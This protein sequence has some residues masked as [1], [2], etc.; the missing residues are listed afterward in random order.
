MN[1][2][3]LIGNGF[4]LAHGLRTS[5][6]DFIFW[7]WEKVVYK[8]RGCYC[9][10]WEDKL[11]TFVL[12]DTQATWNGFMFN[13]GATFNFHKG[14]EIIDMISSD[15]DNFNVKYSML[16]G[17]IIDSLETKGWV[18]IENDYYSLLYTPLQLHEQTPPK[19][20][21]DQLDY[22]KKQLADYLSE[23]QK[24]ALDKSIVNKELNKS[25]FAPIKSCEIAI[26]SKNSLSVFVTNRLND[27]FFRLKDLS[28]RWGKNWD[29][30]TISIISKQIKE[31]KESLLYQN[32]ED[33]IENEIPE[34]FL[35]PD[36]MMFLN[37]NYTEIADQYLIDS[38]FVVN[39]IHG[40]SNNVEGMIFGYG[41][42]LDENYK[43]IQNLNNNEYLKNSKSVR[44]LESDN[45]RK[46][47]SYI[48]SGPYQIYIMGHSCG[49]SDR[50]LLNTLFEHKNCVSIKPFYYEKDN[51]DDTYLEMVQNISRNFTDMKL[52]RDRVVNK[53]F[54]E[55]MPQVKN[56]DF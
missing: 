56:L 31:L 48:E 55:P 10:K 20:L 38:K 24:C 16:F 39:H 8:L 32:I 53:E 46:M 18:D 21:N 45:Y 41:D 40:S 42:E 5:Y 25:I 4:D 34:E 47:L 19:E 17:R 7:Y 12:N 22:I 23:V 26:G 51:G 30:T 15:K 54:C 9:N 11:C 13:T 44:Y 29:S 49:N 35:L 50:T 36:N 27:P 3:V 2:L 33:L 6:M 52:M 37:F 1:R 28:D 43:K 14:Y